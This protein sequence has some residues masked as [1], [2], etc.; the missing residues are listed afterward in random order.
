MFGHMEEKFG[1]CIAFGG[2]GGGGGGGGGRADYGQ[3]GGRSRGSYAEAAGDGRYVRPGLTSVEQREW[4]AAMAN[5][6]RNAATAAGVVMAASPYGWGARAVGGGIA[7][8]SERT[9]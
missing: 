5:R 1:I 8:I 6:G 7:V 4:N 2:S 9:R 3:R